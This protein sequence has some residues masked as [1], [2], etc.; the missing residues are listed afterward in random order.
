MLSIPKK[1]VTTTK[2]FIYPVKFP[3]EQ[4]NRVKIGVDISMLVYPG[5]G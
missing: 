2:K 4:F 1:V 3:Q 5:S